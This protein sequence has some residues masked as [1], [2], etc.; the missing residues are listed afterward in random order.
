MNTQILHAAPIKCLRTTIT[1]LAILAVTALPSLAADAPEPHM[2]AKMKQMMKE[3]PELKKE[4]MTN[5]H[6]ILAMAYRKNVMTFGRALKREAQR[7]DTVPAHFA[8]KAVDE[9]KRSQDQLEREHQEFLRSIPEKMKGEMGEMP[10][11]M[12]EHFRKVDTNL[13][14]LNELVKGDRIESK[15]VLKELQ[16]VLEG[17]HGMGMEKMHGEK[18]MRYEEMKAQDAQLAAEVARMN[19][20]P[21]DKKVGI[22]A[23]IITK[24]VEQRAAMNARMEQAHGHMMGNIETHEEMEEGGRSSQEEEMEMQDTE[25]M[26]SE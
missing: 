2:K 17:Y 5:P 19:G 20:A 7:G 22:M 4:M 18:G 21:E 11:M 10:K 25:E 12:N 1:A 3:H 26:E 15:D 6:H 13:A 23:D 14:R 16:P 8:R 24:L 9:M